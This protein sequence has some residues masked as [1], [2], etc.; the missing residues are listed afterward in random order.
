VGLAAAVFFSPV[1]AVREGQIEVRGIAGVVTAEEVTAALAPAVGVPLARLDLGDLTAGV[2]EIRGVKSASMSREWPTGLRVSIEPRL[3]VAAVRDGGRYVLL[4]VEGVQLAAV[5]Q[6]P[7]GTPEV[8][9]PLSDSD[10]RTLRTVLD[11]LNTIP[12]PLA[13]RISSIG[14]ETRDTVQFT[15]AGGEHVI[16]GDASQSAL[17]AAALD[18][19]L[20][21]PA[22]EY[23]VSA[24]TMPFLRSAPE[25]QG[26]EDAAGT[27]RDQ[28]DDD[29]TSE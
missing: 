25:E 28:V 26:P 15:L 20:K 4:D 6:P 29:A 24:P 2:E 18:I 19:L 5:A 13:A 14:A 11:V 3:P 21:T 8:D 12:A 10:A 1:F 23:N 7:E 16:W 22:V 9:V 17:K 27:D